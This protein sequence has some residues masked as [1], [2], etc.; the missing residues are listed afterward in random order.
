[1][2]E[3]TRDGLVVYY[4]GVNNVSPSLHG[5]Y[6]VVWY[7]NSGNGNHG[8][9]SSGSLYNRRWT[10]NGLK[11]TGVAGDY[12][13]D[14]PNLN[15]YLITPQL[16]YEFVFSTT[17]QFNNTS[18]TYDYRLLYFPNCF[19]SIVL[20][21]DCMRITVEKSDGSSQTVYFYKNFINQKKIHLALTINNNLMCIFIN[22]V[23]VDSYLNI[24]NFGNTA[25]NTET[26][27]L[28]D[29]I[30]YV[31]LHSCRIYNRVLTDNEIYY[32]YIA[33]LAHLEQ[34]EQPVSPD[35]PDI[36]IIEPDIGEIIVPVEDGYVSKV[37]IGNQELYNI[38]DTYSRINKINKY[39]NDEA[40]GIINFMN[41]IQLDLASVK[42]D[43]ANDTVIFK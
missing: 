10:V 8:V 13:F 37:A 7:D 38:K 33:D 42:Y 26:G 39:Q 1:M 35:D 29:E 4:D 14:M 43:I 41:G 15:N 20:R 19:A 2:R 24:I 11:S 25:T 31:T 18:S 34:A 12:Y 27:R 16:T 32:N 17:S 40:Y 6:T 28:M 30:C 9:F 3:I 22:G 36:P 21:E 23:L 5:N